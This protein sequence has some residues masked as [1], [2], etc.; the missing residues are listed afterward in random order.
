VLIAPTWFHAR[1]HCRYEWQSVNH[2]RPQS[3]QLWFPCLCTRSRLPRPPFGGNERAIDKALGQVQVALACQSL[4]NALER[5]VVRPGL[6]VPVR[7]LKRDKAFLT[8]QVVPTRTG[9][10]HPKNTVQNVAW[11]GSW[12]TPVEFA[13]RGGRQQRFDTTPLSISKRC[14]HQRL[15]Y[16]PRTILEKGSSHQFTQFCYGSFFVPALSVQDIVNIVVG[17]SSS[18]LL[19]WS[20]CRTERV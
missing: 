12:A 15:L 9:S 19:L 2:A 8:G 3:L 16:H 20:V 10:K 4:H 17:Y 14:E 18:T 1:P 13:R 6:Q 5:A 7:G 11:I